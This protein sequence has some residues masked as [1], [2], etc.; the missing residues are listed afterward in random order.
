MALHM[1]GKAMP[2]RLSLNLHIKGKICN[3]HIKGPQLSTCMAVLPISTIAL[4]SLPADQFLLFGQSDNPFPLTVLLL[5][6]LDIPL[7]LPRPAGHRSSRP[8]IS[9]MTFV[10]SLRSASGQVAHL[11][12]KPTL[13]IRRAIMK[14]KGNL[15]ITQTMSHTNQ[16]SLLE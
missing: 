9:I 12:A 14:P 7:R 13:D 15:N 4:Q 2:K 5:H 16:K 1:D 10:T 3:P 11:L 6:T 8:L